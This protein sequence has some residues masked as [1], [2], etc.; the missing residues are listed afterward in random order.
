MA[1]VGAVLLL[2]VAVAA[3]LARARESLDKAGEPR[4]VLVSRERL[5]RV[6]AWLG[7]PGD[8]LAL[9]WLGLGSPFAAGFDRQTR[10]AIARAAFFPSR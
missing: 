7:S 9:I 6:S 10:N 8:D 5:K 2:V 3:Q 1:S 4:N